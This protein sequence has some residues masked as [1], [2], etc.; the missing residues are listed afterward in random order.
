MNLKVFDFTGQTLKVLPWGYFDGRQVKPGVLTVSGG[1]VSSI[2]KEGEADLKLPY[3]IY[4]VIADAHLHLNLM[5]NNEPI[6]PQIMAKLTSRGV[7]GFR[8]CGDKSEFWK[9]AKDQCSYLK[10]VFSGN[11]LYKE[12]YYGRIA[13]VSV[14]N[15]QDAQKKIYD[16]YEN[17]AKF[18]KVFVT[19]LVSLKERGKVG[20]TG[21]SL[22]ELK[23][24]VHT[25]H[26]LGLEVS[27]HANGPEGIS[28]CLDAGVDTI[29]HGYYIT[30]ELLL[31]MREAGT[32]WIPTVAAIRNQIYREELT[33]TERET[34]YYVYK[35]QLLKIKRAFELGVKLGLGTDS[36][37]SFLAF[38][39]A[40]W[41]EMDL[42]LKAGIPAVDVIKIA[43]ENNF[44][45]LKVKGFGEI[46]N[47]NFAKFLGLKIP[48][49]DEV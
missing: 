8:E 15:V 6:L 1:I 18:I 19:G 2:E 48:Y 9:T 31:K 13:G 34:A 49:G 12:G 26:K 37:T 5:D 39:E 10:G 4:P 28:L 16:L 46:K 33:A 14:Q 36:G 24:I 22:E 41:E 29:E 21:F 45:L 17:G 35:E 11:G 3:Y 20:P 7:M 47:G 27:A 42:Y 40:V 44:K 32:W 25:A 43:A 23:E 38:G 30:E